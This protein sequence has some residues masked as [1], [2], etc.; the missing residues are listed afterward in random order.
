VC[1]CVCVCACVFLV[2][3]L[4]RRSNTFRT[5]SAEKKALDRVQE[6]MYNEI[7][8]AAEVHRQTRAYAQRHIRP[9]MTML[10]ICKYVSFVDFQY[11]RSVQVESHHRRVCVVFP[12]RVCVFSACCVFV[13]E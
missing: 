4:V 6:S 5:S 11:Q 12:G 8:E 3:C 9:G 2:F 13:T 7:R 1:V 10:E